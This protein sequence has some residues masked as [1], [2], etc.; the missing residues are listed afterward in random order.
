MDLARGT[1]RLAQ[2]LWK[3]P[4]CL[5]DKA[6]PAFDN[7]AAE[8]HDLQADLRKSAHAEGILRPRRKIDNPACYERAAVIDPHHDG[9]AGSL[10]A[11]NDACPERKRLMGSGNAHRFIRLPIRS[12]FPRRIGGG[13]AAFR[14]GCDRQQD[15]EGDI[16]KSTHE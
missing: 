4:G 6:L 3:K 8:L 10:V 9:A 12:T 11:D 7:F 16:K 5:L 13:D 14:R 2:G 1:P 15:G